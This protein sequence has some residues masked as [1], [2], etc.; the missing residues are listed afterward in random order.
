MGYTHYWRCQ[1]DR[2][3]S[4]P[5]HAQ[6][7][8]EMQALVEAATVPLDLEGNGEGGAVAFNGS[9]DDG[10]E[11]FSWPPHDSFDFCKTRQRPYDTL[12][13]AC[14]AIAKHR[15][16]DAVH[17]SSDGD[18]KDWEEG[19][20]LASAVLGETVPCPLSDNCE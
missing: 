18:P 16:G 4:H 2:I 5:G 11:T 12:V 9:G 1:P 15:L 8:R 20:A 17:V 14:L 3:V 6:T 13:T 10:C 19:V 7:L